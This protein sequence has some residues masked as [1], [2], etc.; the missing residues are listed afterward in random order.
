MRS[1]TM[2]GEIRGCL[3]VMNGV[4]FLVLRRRENY[5]DESCLC[6]WIAI[7]AQ[8]LGLLHRRLKLAH[9]TAIRLRLDEQEAVDIPWTFGDQSLEGPTRA[10]GM[11]VE[12]QKDVKAIKLRHYD[13]VDGEW[14]LDGLEC[15]LG[16]DDLGTIVAALK[17]RSDRLSTRAST[18][19]C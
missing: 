7:Q 6:G 9:E 5:R 10:L 15:E 18:R 19:E 16:L 14:C 4:R 17:F 8:D 13:K 3:E 12:L 1:E 11:V 2:N